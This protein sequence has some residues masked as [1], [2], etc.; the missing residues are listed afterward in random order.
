M[1]NSEL[2]DEEKSRGGLGDG[3]YVVLIVAAVETHQQVVKD[4]HDAHQE[5]EADDALSKQVTRGALRGLPQVSD[6]VLLSDKKVDDPS[7]G[8]RSLTE[9]QASTPHH[10]QESGISIHT[11]PIGTRHSLKSRGVAVMTLA[12]PL[13]LLSKEH[14]LQDA[15]EGDDDQ[16]V[17]VFHHYGVH[18]ELAA[19]AGGC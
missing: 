17:D 7:K 19:G 5:E 13:N 14:I 16:E 8:S 9:A 3:F 15:D 2:G 4:A 11:V 10:C 1:A 18:D 12:L 6:K